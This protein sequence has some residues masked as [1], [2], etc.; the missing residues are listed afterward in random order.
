M[1]KS[2]IESYI[3]KFLKKRKEKKDEQVIEIVLRVLKNTLSKKYKGYIYDSNYKNRRI[4]SEILIELKANSKLVELKHVIDNG[5]F[6]ESIKRNKFINV[7]D[8][9][10]SDNPD[11]VNKFYIMFQDNLHREIEAAI[12]GSECA[13]KRFGIQS[14]EEVRNGIKD[15]QDNQDKNTDSIKKEI[16]KLMEKIIEIIKDTKNSDNCNVIDIFINNVPKKTFEGIDEKNIMS[17]E[18]YFNGRN[19]KDDKKWNDIKEKMDNFIDKL[20]K[21]QEYAINLSCCY[22]VGYYAGMKFRSKYCWHNIQ[23]KQFSAR[24]NRL[25]TWDNEKLCDGEEDIEFKPIETK[26][27]DKGGRLGVFIS[28][29]T[30]IDENIELDEIKLKHNLDDY[31][32]FYIGDDK[33]SNDFVESGYHA[34]ILADQ[35]KKYIVKCKYDSLHIFV[36]SPMGLMYKLGEKSFEFKNVNIYEYIPAEKKYFKLAEIPDSDTIN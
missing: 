29:S 17:L 26:P 16:K 3:G 27:Y 35:I 9:N 14:S 24:R 36:A 2:F 1:I 6:L 10:L 18:E 25:E 32:H 34:S 15:I 8:E 19:L 33:E 21:R 28:V 20:D 5:T 30:R 4:I 31:V 22:S 7:I 11:D 23:L 13:Y 12:M